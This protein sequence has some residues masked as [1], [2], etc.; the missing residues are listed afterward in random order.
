MVAG[1]GFLSYWNSQ[2]N[3]IGEIS[4]Y[5]TQNICFLLIKCMTKSCE[6]CILCITDLIHDFQL[7][8]LSLSI[9]FPSLSNSFPSLS[10]SLSPLSLLSL[11]LPLSLSISFPSLPLSPLFLHGQSTQQCVCVCVIIEVL[12][13]V[14]FKPF[15][16][17]SFIIQF[18]GLFFYKNYLFSLLFRILWTFS[19]LF[20]LSVTT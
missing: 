12:C 1:G 19:S 6:N 13:R 18:A 10:L 9:P 5:V 15:S 20:T 17:C 4:K 7:F 11:S 16:L 3:K 14:A 2:I 8:P